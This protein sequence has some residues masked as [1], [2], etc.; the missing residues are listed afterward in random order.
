MTLHATI[1]ALPAPTQNKPQYSKRIDH[2]VDMMLIEDIKH[3]RGW[4]ASQPL[5]SKPSRSNHELILP[6][7]P[8]GNFF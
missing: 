5:K 8:G 6:S 2:K 1:N 7:V 4:E 3:I